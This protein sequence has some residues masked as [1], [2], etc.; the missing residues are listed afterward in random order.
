M[1]TLMK[2]AVIS[3]DSVALRQL[4]DSS[5]M[6]GCS[7]A[8]AFADTWLRAKIATMTAFDSFVDESAL[9][10][11]FQ[12]DVLAAGNVHAYGETSIDQ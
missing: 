2:K 1:K 11:G 6:A 8:A 10:E 9:M 3:D 7:F 5:F 12:R 4:A